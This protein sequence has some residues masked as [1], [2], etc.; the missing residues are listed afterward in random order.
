MVVLKPSAHP[1]KCASPPDSRQ[2]V[3]PPE[4][5]K[6]FTLCLSHQGDGT[7]Q[8]G[9]VGGGGGPDQLSAPQ[10]RT[11]ATED[12]D[13]DTEEEV[14]C[15]ELL[16]NPV[17]PLAVTYLG[18]CALLSTPWAENTEISRSLSPKRA[19]LLLQFGGAVILLESEE[20]V[21]I[22][23]KENAEALNFP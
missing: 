5:P 20:M 14:N 15:E 16:E 23:G 13:T 10:A 21:L 18:Q 7:I 1:V 11:A 2:G 12:T 19:E 3:T 9:K 17:L 22:E 6:C 4:S 8:G